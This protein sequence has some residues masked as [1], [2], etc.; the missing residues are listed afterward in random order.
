MSCQMAMARG[1]L[2]EAERDEACRQAAQEEPAKKPPSLVRFLVGEIHS[3]LK[4]FPIKRRK[5]CRMKKI[6]LK[7]VLGMKLYGNSLAQGP[8]G[9]V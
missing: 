5:N 7:K 6:L 2:R 4:S 1:L 9:E 8:F 3:L